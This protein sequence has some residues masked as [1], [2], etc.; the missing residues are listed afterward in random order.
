MS[1]EILSRNTETAC[2]PNE[3]SSWYIHWYL[4]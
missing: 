2:Q 4:H 1:A 3:A